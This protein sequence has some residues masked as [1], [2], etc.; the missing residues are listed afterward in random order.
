MITDINSDTFR[1]CSSLTSIII[2]DKVTTIGSSAFQNCVLLE[3]IILGQSIR[4]IG[5]YAFLDCTS[6]QYTEYDGAKYLGSEGNPYHALITVNDV[7]LISC[8]I[9]ENTKFI[10]DN[11]FKDCQQLTS[12]RIPNKV[13]YL[14][15][16]AFK[17]CIG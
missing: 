10:A 1:T 17:N 7:N 2:P 5:L 8:Q 12:I 4:K 15:D 9:H 13:I 6:L 3:S 16:Y 11:S 14:G